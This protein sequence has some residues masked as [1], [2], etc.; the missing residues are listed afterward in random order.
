MIH[1]GN[2]PRLELRFIFLI[3]YNFFKNWAKKHNQEHQKLFNK[4]VE[5]EGRVLRQVTVEVVLLPK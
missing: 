2:F 5:V 1:L 3:I 4:K